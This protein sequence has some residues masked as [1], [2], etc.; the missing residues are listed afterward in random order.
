MTK[1]VV[2]LGV[3][4]HF[5]VNSRTWLQVRAVWRRIK[6]AVAF[7]LCQ[8]FADWLIHI[9]RRFDLS[10]EVGIH[11]SLTYTCEGFSATTR[12]TSS[13]SNLVLAVGRCRYCV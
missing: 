3:P 11:V 8:V 10:R 6:C 2:G 5:K 1:T 4:D 9:V 13:A 7:L 12:L